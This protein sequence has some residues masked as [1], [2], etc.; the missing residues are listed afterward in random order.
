M[1]PRR[2]KRNARQSVRPVGRFSVEL[3]PILFLFAAPVALYS[4]S[5]RYPLAFDDFDLR[6]SNLQI[7][8]QAWRH[9]GLR[10]V[11]DVSFGWTYLLVGT[12]LLWHRL[13][14]VV[15]HALTVVAL[16]A[17]L[18]RL[19]GAVLAPPSSAGSDADLSCGR[20]AF[21]G[22]LI[23]ALHPFGVY[24]VAYLVERSIVMATLFSVLALLAYLEGLLSGRFR[25]FLGSAAL[26]F[27]AVFSK[28]HCV[29]LPAVALALT[30]LLRKPSWSLVRE[31]WP[32]FAMFLL[33]GVLIAVKRMNVIGVPYEPS[34][35][36]AIAQ[37][38]GAGGRPIYLLSFITECWLFF[39]YLFLWIVPNPGWLS[40]DLRQKFAAELLSWP[41][42]AGFLAFV[43]YPMVAAWLLLKG[44]RRGLAGFGLLFPWLFYLTE[45][46]T[47][48]IQEPF[49][50]YRAYLWTAGLAA[51]VPL[52]SPPISARWKVA[53]L[54]SICL[55]MVPLTLNRLESFSSTW[56]LWNDVVEKNTDKKLFFAER[57]YNKRGIASIQLE[58]YADAIRDF[59]ASLDINRKDPDIYLNRGM[60]SMQL[61]IYADALRDFSAGLELNPKEP[62]FYVNRGIIYAANQRYAEAIAE[63]D[64]ALELNANNPIAL[65]NR[66]QALRLAARYDEGNAD[67]RKSCALG[68]PAACG[69]PKALVPFD[70]ERPAISGPARAAR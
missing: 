52:L 47:V 39:K 12:D 66:G 36:N 18:R 48:R 1:Q 60:A 45:L 53:L 13:G 41:E 32:P 57:G 3:L 34:A 26:Y 30:L 42:T 56:K 43:L 6:G 69:A 38:P 63:F 16:F 22:A 8:G 28:E 11:T 51:M 64:R 50:L 23:F 62:G 15:L 29:M 59:T 33:I 14:N 49:V 21:F 67:I 40:V 68:H 27:L 70:R 58:N 5:L 2:Q 31:L 55:A 7:Y 65:F 19:F 46:S 4:G 24:G 37:L 44:G 61:G 54:S 25:W 10:W 9:F 35:Q 20:L 17:L